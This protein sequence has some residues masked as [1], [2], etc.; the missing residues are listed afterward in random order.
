VKRPSHRR[1]VIDL[2]RNP[3]E[4]TKK[5]VLERVEEGESYKQIAKRFGVS[6]RTVR[7]IV[8]ESGRQKK[9]ITPEVEEEIFELSKQPKITIT[10]IAEILSLPRTTVRDVLKRKPLTAT[11][12]ARIREVAKQKPEVAKKLAKELVR[13]QIEAKE[14]EIDFA[15]S[16]AVSKM[17]LLPA[18]D[19]PQDDRIKRLY[20]ALSE[21]MRAVGAN[22][23]GTRDARDELRNVAVYAL[24]MI[25]GAPPEEYREHYDR[26]GVEAM[27]EHARKIVADQPAPIESRVVADFITAATLQA[28]VPGVKR[29]T[30]PL[31]S[32]EMTTTARAEDLKRLSSEPAWREERE[33]VSE[34]RKLKNQPDLFMAQLEILRSKPDYP[35]GPVRG[36]D[37]KEIDALARKLIP[38]K[39][40][41]S[42]RAWKSYADLLTKRRH[43]RTAMQTIGIEEPTEEQ[44]DEQLRAQGIKEPRPKRPRYPHKLLKD[45]PKA[46]REYLERLAGEQFVTGP[47][48][49]LPMFQ[50][51]RREGVEKRWGEYLERVPDKPEELPERAEPWAFLPHQSPRAVASKLRALKNK[52][53]SFL[54]EL[55]RLKEGV[56]REPTA[57]KEEEPAPYVRSRLDE[58]DIEQIARGIVPLAILE[59][60]RAWRSYYSMQRRRHLARKVLQ[61]RGEPSWSPAAVDSYL[62]KA[63][64]KDPRPK[65]PPYPEVAIKTAPE[66]WSKYL[67]SL[68]DQS[69]EIARAKNKSETRR[70]KA[71]NPR[72][73]PRPSNTRKTPNQSSVLRRLLRV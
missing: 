68:R 22:K 19:L 31:L 46:W 26:G 48:P 57:Y 40:W 13:K 7:R 21:G 4:D 52:P 59:I 42:A 11:V 36:L 61:E 63:G 28:Q 14:R 64:V 3:A 73:R 2:I 12:G 35:G 69:D 45:A 53:A 54:T 71:K 15:W 49:R 65:R 1:R 25:R 38:P 67:E 30:Q 44:I 39:L 41:S 34:L 33:I 10:K 50:R 29:R 72:S 23:I 60:A 8:A 55:R 24:K 16:V 58:R 27:L 18:Q 32:E 6:E 66:A 47:R 56:A 17:L 20:R 51:G 5:A 62:R 9:Q 37:K 43:M 70:S